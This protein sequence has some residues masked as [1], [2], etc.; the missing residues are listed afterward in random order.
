MRPNRTELARLQAEK[1]EY[2]IK[3]AK[4]ADFMEKQRFNISGQQY[5][6]MEEQLRGFYILMNGLAIRIKDL[7]GELEEDDAE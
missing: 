6:G 2:E 7:K 4:L 5:E 3:R 1:Y